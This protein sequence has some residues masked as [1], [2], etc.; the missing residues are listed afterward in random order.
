MASPAVPAAVR[1]LRRWS[2]WS[3]R[4][5]SRPA[6]GRQAAFHFQTRAT[7][8]AQNRATRSHLW[9]RAERRKVDPT[10][11]APERR[12]QP[13]FPA[14]LADPPVVVR[15]NVVEVVVQHQQSVGAAVQL[16]Q[17]A[18]SSA[19][20]MIRSQAGSFTSV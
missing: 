7:N 19:A 12:S 18:Q 13:P 2:V 5:R 16:H 1:R 10:V 4:F 15:R 3:T 8:A 14:P 11:E 6:R 17:C 9:T 20:V